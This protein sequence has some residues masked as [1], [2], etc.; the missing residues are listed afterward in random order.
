MDLDSVFPPGNF[1][2]LQWPPNPPTQLP[3][4]YHA[5]APAPRTPAG[6][7]SSIARVSLLRAGGQWWLNYASKVSDW[8]RPIHRPHD[9]TVAP[10][11]AW[12]PLA[13]LAYGLDSVLSEYSVDWVLRRDGRAYVWLNSREAAARLTGELQG[14]VYM[15]SE[16]MYLASSSQDCVALKA[17]FAGLGGPLQFTLNPSLIS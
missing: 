17:R 14:A 1:A 10:V 12:T 2:F 16:F 13:A 9:L 15:G 7:L 3:R 8:W 5:A 6:M 4:A 11:D